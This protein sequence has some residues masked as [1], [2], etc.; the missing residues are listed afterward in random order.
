VA[1]TAFAAT[2][3]SWLVFFFFS[4][5]ACFLQLVASSS[6]RGGIGVHR[7]DI[8]GPDPEEYGIIFRV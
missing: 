7:V 2:F 6:V 3:F 1:V 5:S 4:S 8:Y